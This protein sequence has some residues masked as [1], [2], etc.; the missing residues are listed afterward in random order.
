MTDASSTPAAHPIEGEPL[1]TTRQAAS[2]ISTTEGALRMSRVRR[3]LFGREAPPWVRI[4]R[5]VRY[6]RRD[7]DQW[8]ANA[9]EEHRPSQKRA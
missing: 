4:G 3:R 8:L 9:I 1:L 2:V 5:A 7:L 6:R